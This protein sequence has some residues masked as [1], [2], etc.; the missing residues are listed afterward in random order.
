VPRLSR[1]HFVMPALTGAGHAL[2]AQTPAD[3][4]SVGAF[5]A[6][7]FGSAQ[8]DLATYASFDRTPSGVLPP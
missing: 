2:P 4:A 1:F 5:Y 7:W 3:T 6:A 8:Q